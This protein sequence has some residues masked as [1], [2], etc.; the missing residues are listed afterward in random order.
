MLLA[1]A[2]GILIGVVGGNFVRDNS[3]ERGRRGHE[4][5][6]EFVKSGKIGASR[7]YWLQ[8]SGTLT[9]SNVALFFGYYDD[10]EGCQDAAAALKVKNVN[11][12]YR[13]IPA[14]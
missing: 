7:D 6:S 2:V 3:V 9:T 13:C 5:L 10:Q 8:Q 11:A 4:I 12:G 1:A 14:N